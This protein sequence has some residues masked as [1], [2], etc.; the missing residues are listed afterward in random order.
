MNIGE[1]IETFRR[2]KKMRQGDLAK[3]ANITQSYLSMI[4]GNKTD[5]SIQTLKSIANVLEIPVQ[6]LVVYSLSSNQIPD[7]KKNA[8]YRLMPLVQEI[9]EE[10]F[11]S[12]DKNKKEK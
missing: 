2:K 4:E 12:S 9:I 10:Y 7:D 11:L 1:V 8:Y 3:R 5:A 6:L